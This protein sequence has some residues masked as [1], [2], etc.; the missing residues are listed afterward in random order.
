MS[1]GA[2][3]GRREGVGGGTERQ[4]VSSSQ[5]REGERITIVFRL[6][7]WSMVFRGLLNRMK[8]VC[9][10]NCGPCCSCSCSLN[11]SYSGSFGIVPCLNP[12][13]Q[14]VKSISSSFLRP[15]SSNTSPKRIAMYVGVTAGVVV[16][17]LLVQLFTYHIVIASS[18]SW[19]G[20]S[21]SCTNSPSV[22]LVVVV[23]SL[24]STAVCFCA[25]VETKL[26]DCATHPHQSITDHLKDFTM[27]SRSWTP[28]D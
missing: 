23:S 26:A 17:I 7:I 11:C 8:N 6:I 2:P 10:V 19:L 4:G 16:V 25:R 14:P 15:K 24:W 21:V 20:V 13:K 27:S 22:L 3:R 18:E 5:T 12:R 1:E 28:E 9:R